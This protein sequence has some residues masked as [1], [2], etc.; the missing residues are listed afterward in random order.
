M[1]NKPL[2][3]K[4]WMGQLIGEN[5]SSHENI[6]ERISSCIH[7]QKDLEDLSKLIGAAYEAGFYKAITDYRKEFKKYNINIKIPNEEV[8]SL[9]PSED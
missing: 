8:N 4:K 7:T 5:V 9:N 6:I 1:I 2:I 3:I